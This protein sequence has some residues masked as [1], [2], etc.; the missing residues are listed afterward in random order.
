MAEFEVKYKAIVFKPFKGEVLEGIVSNVNK[1]RQSFEL[2][3]CI[4]WNSITYRWA[5]LQKL[6]HYKSSFQLMFVASRFC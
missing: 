1:V 4:F 3:L 2:Q 6:D 5:S